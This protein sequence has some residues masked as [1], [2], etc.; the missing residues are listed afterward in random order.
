[1]P[2]T[3]ITGVAGFI[4]ANLTRALLRHGH[5]VVGID[6]F[7]FGSEAN[8]A[9]CLDDRRFRLIRGDICR[10][11]DLERAVAGSTTIVHLAAHKIPRYT[12]AYDTL[13]ANSEA[14]RQVV[15]VARRHRARIIAASTS[16]VYGRSTALPFAE[17]GPLVVGPPDVRRWAYAISKMFGEQLLFAA[18][19]RFGLDFLL[20]RFFGGYGPYQNLTWWGGP[21]SVFI[22]CALTGRPMPIHGDGTQVRCLTYVDDYVEALVRCI[23]LPEVRNEVLNLGTD[24][25][26]TILDLA[27]LCWRLVRDDEPQLRM[28]PYETFGKY[29]DVVRRV[30]DLTRLRARLGFVPQTPLATGLERTVAWQRQAMRLSTPAP[31]ELRTRLRFVAPMFNEAANLERLLREIRAGAELLSFDYDVT[32]I[33]DGSTDETPGI[34]AQLSE[35]NPITC[36]RHD[37]NRGVAAAFNTGFQHLLQDSDDQDIVVTLEADCTSDLGILPEMYQQLLTGAEMVLASCYLPGGEIVH[38][39]LLRIILSRGANSSARLILGLGGIHTLSSFFR[40]FRVQA[41]RRLAT[42]FGSPILV[43]GGFECMLEMIAK[44]RV[45]DLEI[46]EVPMVLDTSRRRGK[47][48]MRLMRTIRGYLGLFARRLLRRGW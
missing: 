12:D 8:I 27:R 25:P 37:T 2:Q 24:E 20:V 4:G 29:E 38:T 23:D 35:A 22:R 10:P 30:P 1:M 44:A 40:V 7:S 17:D 36:L 47:S 19:E 46:A 33:D 3:T 26:T 21:Q 43:T 6:N 13:R 32:L 45:D 9:E 15:E 14:M 31:V 18:H 28:V 42:R 34:V 16:D 5:H 41:L 11:A 39:D 48:K